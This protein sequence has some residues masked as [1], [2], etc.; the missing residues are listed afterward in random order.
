MAVEPGGY[1]GKISV[2]F[3]RPRKIDRDDSLGTWGRASRA[4]RGKICV[5]A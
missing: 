3:T 5:I 1:R 2:Y 4:G